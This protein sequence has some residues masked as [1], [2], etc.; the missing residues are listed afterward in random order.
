MQTIK[1]NSVDRWRPALSNVLTFEGTGARRI[2]LHVNSPGVTLAWL[3]DDTG[4]EEGFQFLARAE[5]YAVIEFHA[6]GDVRISLD[7]SD[8]W[9]MCSEAEPT[10]VT[11]IDPVIFTKIANRRHRNP[12]LEEVMYR[13][14]LNMER[15]LAQQAGE[16]EAA[17]VRRRQEEEIGRSAETI[18][19][20]A[21]GAAA[22]AGGGEVQPQEPGAF[23]PGE[24]PGSENDS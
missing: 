18:V 8:V 23:E 4:A 19:T 10:H 2:R 20:D 5:G 11:V 17:F 7:G 9:W 14:Q 22:N 1:L 21:P 16:I 12:E 15:R 13:M 6:E 3:V 24:T